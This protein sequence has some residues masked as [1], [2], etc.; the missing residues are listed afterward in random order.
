MAN[1][2]D[3]LISSAMG[4][5]K[6]GNAVLHGDFMAQAG[7]KS[8]IFGAL[9]TADSGVDHSFSVNGL[10]GLA[11]KLNIT[12]GNVWNYSLESN[13]AIG[14]LTAGSWLD[15][16]GTVD[17]QIVAPQLDALKVTGDL[18]ANLL[19]STEARVAQIAVGGTLRNAD[20]T[21]LGDIGTVKLGNMT[22]STILAG[23]ST[24]PDN[25]TDFVLDRTIK[26]FT[27]T[28][29]L[30]D[31]VVAAANFNSISLGSVDKTAGSELKGIYADAIRSYVRKGIDGTKLTKLDTAGTFDAA[32]NYEVRVF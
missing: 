16:A 18:E 25:I 4:N 13:V 6:L 30:S 1:L 24:R 3:I 26:S 20:L 11:P 28:G 2:D 32:S 9:G 12:V 15:T 22:G 27:V 17:N 8:V 31:S 29:T 5:V 21:I 7:V 10:P 19:L 23:M 14:R